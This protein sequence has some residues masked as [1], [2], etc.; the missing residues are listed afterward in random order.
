MS[1]G[2]RRRRVGGSTVAGWIS[3]TAPARMASS[4]SATA[5]DLE[6]L[7]RAGRGAVPFHVSPASSRAVT[8]GS[9]RLAIRLPR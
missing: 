3:A 9:S 1:H 4:L 7:L 5:G 8:G 2:Q 6:L